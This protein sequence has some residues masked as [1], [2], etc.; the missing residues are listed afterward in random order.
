MA[1]LRNLLLLFMIV[2]STQACD[3]ANN[4]SQ[5]PVQKKEESG[6]ASGFT[7]EKARLIG[8]F[9]LSREGRARFTWPG[10]AMEFRFEGVSASIG[11]ASSDR[12]RFLVEVDGRESELFVT[13]GEL[14][15]RLASDLETGRHS[16][17]VTRLSESF[18][19]ITALTSDP[20]VD[21]KLLVPPDPSARRLLAI[22]D[23]I[24]AGYGVEGENET[25]GYSIETS[26]PLKTYA[27]LAAK[28]SDA[29]LHII[30]WSGIGVW[31]SYGEETPKEPS[32]IDRYPLTLGDDFDSRWNPAQ[33]PPDAVLVAIGTNDYWDD[34]AP[35]YRDAMGSLL[36][37]LRDDYPQTP[38]YLIVSPM[39]SGSV[40]E[41]QKAVLDSF[42]GES[43]AVLDLGII[44]ASDGYGCDYHP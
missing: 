15:Y 35:G 39:L 20:V 24:T 7:G 19:G 37:T 11:I 23:S 17:K 27:S 38:V 31:R 10:S 42:A 22:G 32:I 9:D 16:I 12:V 8:R 33:F 4:S 18:A 21:G 14:V 13:P 34:E 3:R 6:P 25:C 5:N 30:A 29:D 43:V 40:R 26:N 2:S 44:E 36:K 41:Q 1:S 28:A